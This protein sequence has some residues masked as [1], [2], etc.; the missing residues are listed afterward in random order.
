[1][2]NKENIFQSP[3]AKVRPKQFAEELSI[4]ISGLYKLIDQKVIEK[5]H[6]LYDGARAVGWSRKYV[7]NFLKEG[8]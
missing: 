2:D 5:P 8:K 7:D 1:M 3:L 6:P 4:S